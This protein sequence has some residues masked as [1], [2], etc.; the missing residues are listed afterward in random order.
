M[1]QIGGHRL[2]F[3]TIATSV[4]CFPE[5]L[6]NIFLLS[7]LSK[8]PFYQTYKHNSCFML[9]RRFVSIKFRFKSLKLVLFWSL[10]IW[11]ISFPPKIKR[12]NEKRFQ[13]L[14]ISTSDFFIII[15]RRKVPCVLLKIKP[16]KV[17]VTDLSKKLWAIFMFFSCSFWRKEL[18]FFRTSH[19]TS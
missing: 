8:N 12:K 5:Y 19:L 3:V 14:K 13:Y 7:K 16:K 15:S 17:Y 9:K 18:S 11:F 1:K 2:I 4:S 6:H 10:K